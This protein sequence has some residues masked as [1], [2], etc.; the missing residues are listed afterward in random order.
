ME[1]ALACGD[2]WMCLRMDVDVSFHGITSMMEV[3]EA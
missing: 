3:L 2:E 1:V